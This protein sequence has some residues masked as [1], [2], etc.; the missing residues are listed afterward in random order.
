M[1]VLDADTPDKMVGFDKSLRWWFR[2]YMLNIAPSDIVLLLARPT[3]EVSIF[4]SSYN[5]CS[6]GV[7]R[8]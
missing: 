6:S 3:S 8:R 2:R 7:T 5:I 4:E 1:R